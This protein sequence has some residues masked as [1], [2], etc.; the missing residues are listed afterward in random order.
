M[1]FIENMSQ[2]NVNVKIKLQNAKINC[3][4]YLIYKNIRENEGF[5]HETIKIKNEIKSLDIKNARDQ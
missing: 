2:K 4:F 1:I 3:R 5:Y